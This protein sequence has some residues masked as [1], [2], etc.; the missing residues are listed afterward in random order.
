MRTPVMHVY[1]GMLSLGAGVGGWLGGG[2]AVECPDSN[3]NIEKVK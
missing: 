2:R 3:K 1:S